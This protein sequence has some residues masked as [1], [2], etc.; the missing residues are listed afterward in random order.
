MFLAHREQLG[1]HVEQ[2]GNAAGRG[3]DRA[4]QR[5]PPRVGGLGE[6]DQIVLARMLL[7]GSNRGVD[8][9]AQ[10]TEL[11]E[12]QSEEL[13]FLLLAQRVVAEHQQF[14]E[15]AARRFAAHLQQCPG[16]R[17]CY[18]TNLYRCHARISLGSRATSPAGCATGWSSGTPFQAL[19]PGTRSGLGG[20]PCT[21]TAR[22]A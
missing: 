6:A 10:R 7:V 14:S 16:S 5:E 4:K 12:Q 19:R 21:G 17:C 11:V 3:V 22:L 20:S 9:G 18:R 15:R 13:D 8:V 1:P 2:H